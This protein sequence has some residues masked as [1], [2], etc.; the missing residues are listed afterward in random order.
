MMVCKLVYEYI[1]EIECGENGLGNPL[2][3]KTKLMNIL[4]SVLV[5]IYSWAQKMKFE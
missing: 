5:G 3:F 4:N 1:N 2:N